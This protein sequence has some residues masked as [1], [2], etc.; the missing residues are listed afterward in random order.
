MSENIPSFNLEKKNKNFIHNYNYYITFCMY[1]D[2][3]I[4]FI[5]FEALT[6]SVR[7]SKT[8]KMNLFESSL[9]TM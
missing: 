1:A 8:K 2:K 3:L 4:E 6:N 7:H 5:P 9:Y